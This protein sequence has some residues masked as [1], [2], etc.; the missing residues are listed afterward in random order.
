MRPPSKPRRP[1]LSEDEEALWHSIA[2]SVAPLK[3][4]RRAALLPQESDTPEPK[5]RLAGPKAAPSPVKRP[6]PAS[7]PASAPPPLVP[8]ERRLR[9]RLARGREEIAA[10][11]DL[12]GRSQSQAH[13]A[14]LRFLQRAQSEGAKTV[15]V[16]TGKG[17]L[18][19]AASERGVLKRQVPLWLALPDFR[20][21][22]VAIDEAHVGHGGGGAFYVRVRRA[23]ART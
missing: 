3:R 19:G 5:K 2:R 12:H 9:Q 23:R 11:I 7:R 15:L 21:Y 14:L 6:A 4:R 1:K 13:A 20:P 22:V 18:D 10:R 16:I 8:L 17:G